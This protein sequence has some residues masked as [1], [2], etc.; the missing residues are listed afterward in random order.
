M[1]S[2]GGDNRYR[3]P[4]YEC[5]FC[6]GLVF[7]GHDWHRR[8]QHL[9][10][11]HRMRI[12]WG[13][14]VCTYQQSSRRFSDLL[15]HIRVKHR[16]HRGEP[17]PKLESVE[18]ASLSPSPTRRRS[19]RKAAR[20]SRRQF[21][22]DD[23]GSQSRPGRSPRKQKQPVKSSERQLSS[24]SSGSRSP[25]TPARS[26]SPQPS[27]SARRGEVDLNVSPPPQPT[28]GTTRRKTLTP[29]KRVKSRVVKV[30]TRPEKSPTPEKTSSHALSP[31][32]ATPCRSPSR[33]PTP[34][35]SLRQL[36]KEDVQEFL[37]TTSPEI[38]Q[39]VRR[40]LTPR[41]RNRGV[42]AD[43]RPMVVRTTDDGLQISAAGVNIQIQG[44]V[45][46]QAPSTP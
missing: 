26:P 13:C 15:T 34:P 7:K 11:E 46:E 2:G 41:V 10:I 1:A 43:R 23:H 18:A 12:T 38:R 4:D 9:R 35:A 6:P 39:R 42:Q 29:T 24:S 17:E 31:R 28:K 25:G 33:S 21:H 40:S 27:T 30:T 5:R 16:H 36:T 32:P 8:N 44:P 3:Q 20:E 45:E 19:P 22:T 37:R 14:P